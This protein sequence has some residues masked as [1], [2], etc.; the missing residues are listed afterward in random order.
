MKKILIGL[1]VI[2]IIVGGVALYGAS[3]SGKLIR[4]AITS[5]APKATGA[6]VTLDKVK[7]SL[8]G[9]HAGL[10]GLTVGNPEGFKS[11]YAFKVGNMDVNIDMDSLLGDVIHVREVRIDGANLI[12]EIGSRGNNISKIQK[13][14]ENYSRSLGLE[15]SKSDTAVKF[16]VDNVYITG[17]KVKL[18]SDLLGGKGVD[19]SLPD[20]HL[21][22]IG[23]EK[24]AATA[25]EVGAKI[26][27]AVNRGLGK[28][29]TK[30]MISNGLKG[31]KKKLIGN[32]LKG[33]KKKLGD[34]FK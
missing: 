9:G 33:V 18:A 10:S 20:I 1:L 27:G 15:A 31:V 23:T 8:L 4:Q 34:I 30:D 28:I 19:L 14:I 25:G 6:K 17:T 22:D 12:Y 32:G 11:D 3:Q 24:K 5:Y 26:F 2:I 29:V 7:V 16:I 13:N 21:K